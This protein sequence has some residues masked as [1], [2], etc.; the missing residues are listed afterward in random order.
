MRHIPFNK[1]SFTGHELHYICKAVLSGKISGDGIYTEKCSR[2]L[3][4]KFNAPRV[5]LTNSGTAALEL[6]SILIDLKEGDEV[7]APSY[8]FPSTINAF[9]LRGAK[10]V[11]VDIHPDTMNID[12]SLVA[13]RITRKTRAI[14][15]VHYAGISCDMGTIQELAKKHDLAV[16]EDAAQGVNSKYKNEYLGT[17]GTFGCYSFH[18]TKNVMAGEGG[19]LV[20]NDTR[21]TARAEIIREK[22]TDRSKHFRGEVD[23]YTWQEI[24][25]SYLPSDVLAAFLFAQL[26][27]IDEITRKRKKIYDTY[28]DSLR[29]LEKEGKAKLPFVPVDCVPNF[30]MFYLVLQSENARDELMKDLSTHGIT[31]VFHFIPLHTSPMG[32]KLGWK[33]GDLPVTESMSARLLRLPFYNDMLEEEQVYVIEKIRDF[34]R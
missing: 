10:P 32:R 9:M 14:Y 27:A 24:G 1:P 3:E 17:I 21:F 30:H 15:P 20:I 7:I 28:F 22:G 31:S 33:D 26:E 18:E 16:V 12:V 19:A 4:K 2:F 11:F 34:F 8:T 25:S 6:A 29:F 13:S 5:L 23:K